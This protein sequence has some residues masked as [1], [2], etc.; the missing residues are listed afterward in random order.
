MASAS[1]LCVEH[2][3]NI[4]I[5]Y[6]QTLRYW[7]KNFMEKQSQILALGFDEKFIRTWNIILIIVLLVS[8][9]IHL[10]IIRLYFHVRAMLL[11]SR[12]H[13]KAFTLR[14]LNLQSKERAYILL[15]KIL[16]KVVMILDLYQ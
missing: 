15:S 3:E 12:I 5:H 13:T 4:G 8:K 16:I 14:K 9:L 2:L 10:E 11:H 6:Y 1:R 7:R